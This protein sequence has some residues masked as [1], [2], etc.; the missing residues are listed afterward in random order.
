MKTLYLFNPENDMALAC[1]DPYYMPPA[2]A[3][4]MAAELSVLAAWYA[5]PGDGVLVDASLCGERMKAQCPLLPLVEF[6]T[7]F[8]PI[9]NK[10]S[11]WGWNP[12]LLRRLREAGVD[13]S[14]CPTNE[15]MNRIRELS[16]RHTAVQMLARLRMPSS[17]CEDALSPMHSMLVGESCL[18]H[19]IG[20]IEEFLQSHADAVLKSP[21]SGSGRGIQYVCGGEFPAPFKGWAAHILRT[22]QAVVGEPLY[23]K[24]VDFA[25]EFFAEAGGQ[26][27]FAGYSFFET[28]KRGIYKENLLASDEAIENR[29]ATYIPALLLHQLRARLEQELAA[30]IRGDYQGYLGVDMMICRTSAAGGYAIHPCV[31][32]NLRM[33]M[34]VVARLVYDKYVYPGAEGRYA[35]EYYACPGEAERAHREM[36]LQYPLYIEHGRVKSGYLSLTP[37]DEA[38]AYQAFIVVEQPDR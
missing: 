3:C 1:G 25:M 17:L 26:V 31:E 23:D 37:V 24:V 6:V 36:Q 33:N 15:G 29:L 14:V 18:L 38:T 13:T 8:S 7:G 12:S 34:G 11:P 5:S 20:E 35:I 28:D 21:W 2:S 27:R 16:G 19:S 9:Y 30:A 22:Q 4:R 32:I 10:M